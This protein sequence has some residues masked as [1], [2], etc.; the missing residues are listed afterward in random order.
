MKPLSPCMLY[1]CIAIV[2][3]LCLADT[4]PE[5]KVLEVGD[6]N[7][8]TVL[9][10][11]RGPPGDQGLQGL[12]GQMGS[13]G[14][15]GKQ[16]IP[17]D[18]GN[19]GE[20]GSEGIRGPPGPTGVPGAPGFPGY[21]GAKGDK[22]DKGFVCPKEF[23]G[24][25]NCEQLKDKGLHLNG[26]YTI[27]PD[28]RPLSV[29][30]DMDTD[31]GGWIVFQRRLDG[32]GNF[33][34]DWASYQNGFGSQLGEFWL[35]NEH[36]HRLTSS[37][38]YQLR[39]D[40][41]D[42]EG[43]RT[44]ATYSDFRVEAEADQYIL[45]YGACTGGTAGD[46]LGTQKDQAFSTIDQNNDKSDKSGQSCAEYFKGGWWFESCHFSNLN[47]EYLKGEHEMKGKGIIWYSF[48]GNFNSLKSTE[49]KFRPQA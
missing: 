14:D 33:N 22:G 20:K 31:G 3:A 4:C 25:R 8:L 46:S 24:A 23:S 12:P 29:L 41:E 2:T 21:G 18:K 28:G 36:L 5:V 37:G 43:N 19:T 10:G 16:G 11:C 38:S 42:F 7:R 9:Q 1:V 44:Y 27:Y 40:L 45:R 47:G 15:A 30:C 17:G 32:S 39:F 26:W 35:G 48:R 6:S 13:K 49:I 34:R